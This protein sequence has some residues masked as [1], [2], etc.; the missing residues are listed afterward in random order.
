[1]VRISGYVLQASIQVAVAKELAEA[2]RAGKIGPSASK[3][4]LV[5]HSMGSVYSNGLLH[6]SP[7]L[8]DAALLTGIAYNLTQ[9]TATTQSK[10]HRLASVQDPVAYGHLDGGWL[11]V[12]DVYSLQEG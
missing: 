5:A 11:G 12:V 3:I 2:L 6:A 10:Q 7:D 1:M 9:Q 4:V 8:V